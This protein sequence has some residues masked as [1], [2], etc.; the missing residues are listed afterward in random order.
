VQYY[1][2]VPGTPVQAADEKVFLHHY[3]AVPIMRQKRHAVAPRLFP[4]QS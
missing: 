4:I 3:P 1:Q 2:F